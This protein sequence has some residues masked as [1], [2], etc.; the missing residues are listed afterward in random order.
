MLG[1]PVTVFTVVIQYTVVDYNS[2]EYFKLLIESHYSQSYQS[3]KLAV[4]V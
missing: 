1:I 2:L 3:A 4:C